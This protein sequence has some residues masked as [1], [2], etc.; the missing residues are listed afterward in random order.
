MFGQLETATE[1][2]RILLAAQ[3]T[4]NGYRKPKKQKKKSKKRVSSSAFSKPCGQKREP[5]QH[6]K[7]NLAE[8][9]FVAGKVGDVCIS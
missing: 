3:T 7:L 1:T 5:S 9:P 8:I 2:N 6:Y 4:T